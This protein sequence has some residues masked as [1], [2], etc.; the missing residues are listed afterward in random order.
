MSDL[1]QCSVSTDYKQGEVKWGCCNCFSA[2]IIDIED[3][4]FMYLEHLML[5]PG[6]ASGDCP[7]HTVTQLAHAV[8]VMR[9]VVNKKHLAD[10]LEAIV[11]Q[12]GHHI[13]LR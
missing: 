10:K 1:F 7:D 6:G 2:F 5:P 4:M 8:T 12:V 13:K 9:E 3:A 11:L